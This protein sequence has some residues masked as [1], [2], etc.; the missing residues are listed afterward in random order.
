MRYHGAWCHN[1]TTNETVSKIP[2]HHPRM[3]N[4]RTAVRMAPSRSCSVMCTMPVECVRDA[5]QPP[6]KPI[7]MVI[8]AHSTATLR[9]TA[10][11]ECSPIV[12]VWD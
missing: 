8:A 5:A 3:G 1:A 2:G 7:A 9:A 10:Q 4:L 6:R 11:S 12:R